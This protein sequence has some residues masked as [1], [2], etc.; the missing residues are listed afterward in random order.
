MHR[1]KIWGGRHLIG[2]R[3]MNPSQRVAYPLP[4]QLESLNRR[5]ARLPDT[6]MTPLGFFAPKNRRKNR[7][8]IR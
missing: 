7:D 1:A 5:R 8:E 2:V 6:E 3:Y 4:V